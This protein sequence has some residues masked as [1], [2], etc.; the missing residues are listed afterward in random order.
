[1]I[2]R[3]FP[4]VV[5]RNSA[6]PINTPIQVELAWDPD[7]DP[8]AVA[9]TCSLS[10]EQSGTGSDQDIVWVFGRDLLADGLRSARVVGR[11]DVKMRLDRSD[12]ARLI[13]CL[14]SHDGHADLALPVPDASA[15][16]DDTRQHSELGDEDVED[17]IDEFL[18]ELSE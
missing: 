6:G 15:F 8:F 17:L 16:L 1:M 12:Q 5:V 9:M 2:S 7:R 3:K 4:A 14:S 10:A 18:K 13:I 11:G